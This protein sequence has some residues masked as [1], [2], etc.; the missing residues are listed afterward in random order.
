M[1]K[2]TAILVLIAILVCFAGCESMD[3]KKATNLYNNGQYAEALELFLELGSYED[4][5]EMVN[6]C[7]Y[8]IANEKMAAKEYLEAADLFIQLGD[9]K[10]SAAKAVTCQEE[11]VHAVLKGVWSYTLS[12]STTSITMSL[13]FNNGEVSSKLASGTSSIGNDGDYTLDVATRTIY[14]TYDNG[15]T[16]TFVYD[17]ESE[18]YTVS[19]DSLTL[20]KE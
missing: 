1:K 14:I 10:D 3:Y 4:S 6:A 16:T 8:E 11:Y 13:T 20:T 19:S 12:S 17:F 9:Y 7:R 15:N 5:A 18:V 2:F